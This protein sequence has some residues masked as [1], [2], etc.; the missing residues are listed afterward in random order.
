MI[1]KNSSKYKRTKYSKL[2]RKKKLTFKDMFN[3]ICYELEHEGVK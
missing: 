2:F 3:Q 1:N